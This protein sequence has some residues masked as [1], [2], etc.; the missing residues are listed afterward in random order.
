MFSTEE[1][2]EVTLLCDA[3]LMKAVID[4][5]GR[6]VRTKP[7]GDAQFRAVVRICPSPTFY[8]WIFGWSGKM[9]I[10][11]PEAVCRHYR[12]LLFQEYMMY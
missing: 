11:G 3:E 2:V 12:D 1:T 5:F 7:F 6:S 10:E 4:H 9:R 8:R